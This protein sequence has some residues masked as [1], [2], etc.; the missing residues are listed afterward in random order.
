MWEISNK[1]QI[2]NLL[3]SL[4]LGG[5]FCLCY[6]FLRAFR[7]CFRSKTLFYFFS[8]LLFFA[9][10][11]VV[12]FLLLLALTYGEIRG[13]VILGILLGFVLFRIIFSKITLWLFIKLWSFILKLLSFVSKLNAAL[14]RKIISG[15]N[16]IKTYFSKVYKKLLKK[17][18][19]VLYNRE[20]CEKKG[21]KANVG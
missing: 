2:I 10:S 16:F 7:Y 8:D 15:I 12:T 13:Y 6:D 5:I 4:S 1:G 19:T 20:K 3:Y 11:G 9:L 17:G 21:E 18:H 14:C